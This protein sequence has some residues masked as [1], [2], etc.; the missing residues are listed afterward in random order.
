MIKVPNYN[1]VVPFTPDLKLYMKPRYTQ[2]ADRNELRYETTVNNAVAL[3]LPWLPTAQD[4][5][6]VYVNHIRL[7]NPR[8]RDAT[9]GSL[10]EVY[11]VKNRII[12]F[13]QPISGLVTVICD[14]QATHHWR[15]LIMNADNI[16]GF[17]VYKEAH[18]IEIANWKIWGGQVKGL[19]YNVY[20]DPGPTY[21]AN[22]YVIIDGCTPTSFNGNFQV[23]RSSAG[24][25][26][27]RGNTAGIFSMTTP[28]TIK[29]FG[30]IKAKE[31]DGIAL[32]TEPVIIT[33]PHHGY[34]RLTA[35]RKSIAYV[36]NVGYKGND[37]FSW[38]M[39][40]QHGQIAEPKCVQIHIADHQ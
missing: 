8:V 29:G 38:S 19:T 18:D 34:A 1:V 22:T 35:N 7:V 23:T 9:G 14:T 26:T 28:G 39:I 15:S 20:F 30:N 33:Q 5:V 37:T 11:N 10:F 13:N 16:Q 4:W 17:Y 21:R 31:L 24:S 6:E 32:Y 2:D 40:N 36:P 12:K 25:V 27:F 3:E